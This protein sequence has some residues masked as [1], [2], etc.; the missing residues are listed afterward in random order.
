MIPFKQRD[1]VRDKGFDSDLLPCIN[2]PITTILILKVRTFLTCITL[3][4]YWSI[5]NQYQYLVMKRLVTL[6]D[7][8]HVKDLD[9]HLHKHRTGHWMEKSHKLAANFY[10]L[11]QVKQSR[12]I[13]HHMGYFDC[14]AAIPWIF[15][16]Y[17]Q[18]H[19]VYSNH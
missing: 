4:D 13:Q 2:K 19:V 6:K 17:F 16:R 10:H 9:H 1:L 15:L 8:L 7:M 12:T 5:L 3:Y 14:S 18:V 11:S